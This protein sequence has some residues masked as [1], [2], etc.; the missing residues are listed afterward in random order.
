MTDT[1]PA[2]SQR[3]WEEF[4]ARTT[5]PSQEPSKEDLELAQHLLGHSRGGKDYSHKQD[6]Q[7]ERDSVSLVQERPSP[8]ST[9]S[10]SAEQVRHDTLR[11]NSSERGQ[12]ESKPYAPG[13]PRSDSVP[14]GQVC[15]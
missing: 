3:H 8:N 9:M 5:V 14:S 13:P 12:T 10:P 15:R 11:S 6:Y 1:R 7:T 2:P 4:P